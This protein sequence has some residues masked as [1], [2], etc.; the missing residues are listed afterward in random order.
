VKEGAIVKLNAS[1]MMQAALIGVMRNV[2]NL[3]QGRVDAFGA[4]SDRGWEYH[5][6]GAC[7]EYAVAKLLNAFY[8]GALGNLG[9]DDVGNFQ[10]RT[11]S[12]A[13]YELIIHPKD[14]DD[15]KF[16][17]VTGCAPLFNVVGWIVG[18]DG[19]REEFW[20]DPAGSRPAFFVPHSALRPIDE[21]R[22]GRVTPD[23]NSE[24]CGLFQA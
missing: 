18:R 11:R 16:V 17:L 6:Q 1:E 14:P 21:L 22:E 3:R 5:I 9:A 23:S 8:N 24:T 15:R 7:G 2:T 12:K 10:V 20:K 19:K 13:H 4:E